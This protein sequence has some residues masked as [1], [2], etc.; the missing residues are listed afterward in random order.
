MSMGHEIPPRIKPENDS[1]YFEQL[2]KAVFQSGFSWAVIR[3]KWPNF[4][5]AFD[6]FSLDSVAG[7]AMVTWSGCST[8]RALYATAARSWRQ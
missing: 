5:R 8:T 4:V 1:G 2:T 6:G 7:T 3:D